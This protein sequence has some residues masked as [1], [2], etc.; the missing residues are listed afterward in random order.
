MQKVL[1]RLPCSTV[2]PA[3]FFIGASLLINSSPFRLTGADEKAPSPHVP[4]RNDHGTGARRNTLEPADPDRL[5]P[6]NLGCPWPLPLAFGLRHF[7]VPRATLVDR[8]NLA[9]L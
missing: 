5:G 8:P 9:Q 1:T 4:T 3:D 7:D 2:R 6:R